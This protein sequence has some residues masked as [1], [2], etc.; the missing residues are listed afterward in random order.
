MANRRS[1]PKT[2]LKVI[3]L[4]GLEEIGK[5]MTVLEYGNDIIIIDCGLAF[6]EDDML[7]IDLVIPDITYLAKNVEKIRGIVLTHG[8]EDHIGALPYVL[9]QLK[10]PVFGTLLT[11]G[12]LENKLR[13]H[14]MLDKTT[15]HTVVPGEKVK[16]GEMVVEFI[17]TNHSIA[18]SV[19]L[20]IQ[21]PVGMVIHT[22]DFKVDYTP[23]DGDIIDLQRFAELG[24]QGVLLLMSDSTNAERKGF[25]M[26]EK[27]VGKVFER[28]FEETPRNRIMV[29]TFSSNIHRIQQIINAAYM[30]GRKV[31]IIGRSMVNAVKTASEL[32]YLWVPPRTLIDINEIKNYRDEQLVIITTGSQG[33]TMSALSRIANSEHKQVS[34]KPDDKIIIS[35]SAIPGNEKNVIRVV[36]ELLK[37]G[38]DVVYGGIED[39]HVSGHARQEELKLMLALTK[40]KFFMPVHG[41]YMHLSSHRDLAISMGMDKKNI[42]VNKLGDVLELSKNEAKVTGTVPT[43]QVMVDGLGVGDVGNIVLRDRKHLSE[44]GLMVVVVSM[45]EETGQIV[46]GPDIISRGFVYVRESEGLMD[47]AREVVVKALQECEEKNITSWNYIK[48]LIKDT[49][50]NYIWQKTKRSPMILPIIMEV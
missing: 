44:D 50:K 25:T 5:N 15:L 41:E 13:E 2:R 26:S 20:A 43:G 39:I 23:I 6:P 42:F 49:L 19:A 27:N 46:A 38:A 8:H 11:L 7:G 34:V 17:H 12:L 40:P 22:G 48:N 18:D 37:K 32:D 35:A 29:A 30:Y 9:K 4:G 33:E 10:V 47:G 21:T 1:K 14:K 3:A 24:S 31:A 45:E 16:L 28:I 36:N